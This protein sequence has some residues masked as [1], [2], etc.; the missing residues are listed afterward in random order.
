MPDETR[1]TGRVITCPTCK[2]PG[3]VES[4]DGRGLLIDH[5]KRHIPCRVRW[6]DIA[7]GSP[8]AV[9]T[10]QQA[11]DLAYSELRAHRAESDRDS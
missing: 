3:L 11:E 10:Q 6:A 4:E 5:P 7:P 8:I 9:L 2:Q 1:M